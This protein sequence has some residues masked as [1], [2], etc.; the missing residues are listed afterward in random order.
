[1]FHTHG[2][3]RSSVHEHLF[4]Y[5]ESRGTESKE[6]SASDNHLVYS[7]NEAEDDIAGALDSADL[8]RSKGSYSEEL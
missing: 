6:R 4:H 7:I 1:M 3:Y 2:S 8:E 5:Q